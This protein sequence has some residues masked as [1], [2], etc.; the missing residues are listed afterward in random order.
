[1]LQTPTLDNRSLIGRTREKR[2]RKC[3]R[4]KALS[5]ENRHSLF[6]LMI[7]VFRGAGSHPAGA[8]LLP[9]L[10]VRKKQVKGFLIFDFG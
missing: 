6:Q 4:C 1:M 10:P 9:P 5:S 7:G 3:S 2:G 8:E